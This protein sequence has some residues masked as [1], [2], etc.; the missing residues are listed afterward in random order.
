MRSKPSRENQILPGQDIARFICVIRDQRV[1]LDRD[2][3]AIYGTETRALNQAV[4]RNL[5][6]F[7]SDF[8]FELTRDEILRISQNVTSLR[9]LKFSKQVRAFTEHGALMVANVLNSSRASGMSVF[10]IRA[11]IRMREELAANSAI[12]KRLAEIDKKLL[13]HDLALHD[14]FQKLRPLLA[15]A[16]Q[17]PKPEIGFHVK[18][19]AV[20]YRIRRASR[21]AY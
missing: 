9:K 3:A 4:K 20:P 2:L 5:S 10:V 16:P 19:D 14:I 15:P 21:R 6:R 12:L 13:M 1:I 17:P 7:P 11:F 8:M 18:E